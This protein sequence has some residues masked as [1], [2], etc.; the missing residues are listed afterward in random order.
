MIT[1]QLAGFQS[2]CGKRTSTEVSSDQK[3]LVLF[4]LG[5]T[6]KHFKRADEGKQRGESGRQ[7]EGN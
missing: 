6:F 4:L 1:G 2:E 3:H 7:T 5:P